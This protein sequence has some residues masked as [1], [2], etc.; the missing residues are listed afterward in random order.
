MMRDGGSHPSRERRRRR[1]LAPLVL[2]L[3]VA[4]GLVPGAVVTSSKTKRAAAVLQPVATE[5]ELAEESFKFELTSAE[6]ARTTAEQGVKFGLALSTLDNDGYPWTSYAEYV[7]D[8]RGCPIILLKD[9]AV[10]TIHL[11]HTSRVS[12]LL[13]TS[14][15][16]PQDRSR[17]TLRGDANRLS[18]ATEEDLS[19]LESAFCL[20]HPYAETLLRERPDFALWRIE[21]SSVFYVGGF[22][23]QAQWVDPVDYFDALP[24]VVAKG[25]AELV[26]EL[27]EHKHLADLH[28]AAKHLLDVP[29]ADAVSVVHLDKLGIDFRVQ[30]PN[31]HFE[32]FRVAY[33][34]RPKSVDD[35]KSEV[36][37]LLQEAWESDN[38]LTFDGN[39]PDKPH[40]F[41]YAGTS[42]DGDS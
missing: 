25:A 2:I 6:R 3:H 42:S 31:G 37:K 35:A 22:G 17:L 34:L 29:D 11:D 24:D 18:A 39:Y 27:N 9:D 40:V 16:Q 33:R 1:H 21:P 12:V 15:E 28:A 26:A 4:L 23:V 5:I 32:E 38:G 13:R 10:H 7:L 19:T 20:E 36:N 14:Q 8:K 41:Q 30:R